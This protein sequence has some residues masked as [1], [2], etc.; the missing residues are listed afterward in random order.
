M[1]RL[2]FIDDDPK[3]QATLGMVLSE[4]YAV[5]SALTA[6]E[7]LALLQDQDPDV[8]LLDID[9][10][11]GPAGQAV[12]VRIEIN[13]HGL[14]IR[15]KGRRLALW[16][17]WDSVLARMTPPDKAAAKFLENPAGLLMEDL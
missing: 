16:A 13:A 11:L 2:L 14:K 4:Q 3:A 5:L 9:L 15:R 10:A 7:G 17:G 1:V 8:V 12:P 6:A